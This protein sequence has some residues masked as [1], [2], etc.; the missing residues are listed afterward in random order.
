V[1]DSAAFDFVCNELERLTQLSRLEARGTV[2]LA[3]KEAG[4]ATDVRPREMQVVLER[5]LPRELN[6]RGVTTGEQLCRDVAAGVL[7]LA[8]DRPASN[9]PDAIFSRLAGGS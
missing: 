6:A 4:L 5:V 9:T 2:R 1:A 7:R 8:D 3:L